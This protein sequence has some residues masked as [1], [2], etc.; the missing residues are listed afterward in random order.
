MDDLDVNVRNLSGGQRQT[1]AISRALYSD[2]ELLILDE[3][4]SEISVRET[5]EVL[6]LMTT[7][8]NNEG[9]S[10]IFITHTLQEAFQ[11]ADRLVTLRDGKIVQDCSIEETKTEEVVSAMIG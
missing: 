5:E 8:R 11:V 6:K 4:T 2:P 9:I 1:I 10:V 3:P 7:L